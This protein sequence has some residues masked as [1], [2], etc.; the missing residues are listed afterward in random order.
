MQPVRFGTTLPKPMTLAS[1][2]EI[3]LNPIC[4][5]N[6]EAFVSFLSR[7]TQEH[8]ILL[9]AHSSCHDALQRRLKGS[10][11][12]HIIPLGVLENEQIISVGILSHAKAG[13]CRWAGEVSIVTDPRYRDRGLGTLLMQEFLEIAKEVRL[14]K[15]ITRFVADRDSDE[16]RDAEC[17]SLVRLSI[18]IDHYYDSLGTSHNLV[19]VEMPLG[20]WQ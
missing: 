2:E 18:I 19:L 20:R 13:P 16:M 1:G 17:S 15:L 3:T 14:D 11:P 9:D 10:G 12:D 6:H 8:S 5:M 7:I 4:S